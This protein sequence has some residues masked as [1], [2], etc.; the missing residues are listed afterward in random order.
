[1]RIVRA[2]RLAPASAQA[3]FSESDNLETRSED[4]IRREQR[5]L[6]SIPIIVLSGGNAFGSSY[7]KGERLLARLRELHGTLAAL[8]TRG[9]ER[10]V[11]GAEHAIQA[12]HPGI[13]ADAIEEVVADVTAKAR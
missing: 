4:E 7:A 1:M 9:E 5:S 8:S 6:G 11:P 13:V 2:Q 10:L 12:S 3:A